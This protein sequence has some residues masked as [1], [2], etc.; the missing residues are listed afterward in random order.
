LKAKNGRPHLGHGGNKE[1]FCD[2]CWSRAPLQTPRIQTPWIQTPERHTLD[3]TNYWHDKFLKLLNYQFLVSLVRSFL[4]R[5]LSFRS[6]NFRSLNFR[7]LNFWS[8]NFGSLLFRNLNLRSLNFG[9]LNFRSLSWPLLCSLVVWCTY[10]FFTLYIV[11][12]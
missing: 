5:S 8:L 4:V 12:Y 9:S 11:L 10:I 1:L 6:L 3:R 7:S 2:H